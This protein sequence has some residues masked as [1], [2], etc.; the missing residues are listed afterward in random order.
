VFLEEHVRCAANLR[1][2]HVK[3]PSGVSIRVASR[4]EANSHCG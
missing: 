4:V 1:A 3:P 2:T